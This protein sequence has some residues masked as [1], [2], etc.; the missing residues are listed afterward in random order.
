M[1]II[2][3]SASTANT[4]VG[5][6]ITYTLAVTNNETFNLFDISVSD[7]LSSSLKFVSN[8]VKINGLDSPGDS[9]LSGIFLGT[10]EPLKL[11]TV[12]F[13]AEV[14]SQPDNKEIIN[15]AIGE[16]SYIDPE[17]ALPRF[18]TAT[19][20]PFELTVNSVNLN[21]LKKSDKKVVSIGDVVT[22]TVN[23]INTGDVNLINV[24][25]IDILPPGL[26]LINGTFTINGSVLNNVNLA[27]GVIIPSI[28]VGTT[29]LIT[30]QVRVIST[31]SCDAINEARARY[32][33]V[34]ADG[35]SG[36]G[37]SKITSDSVVALRTNI[38]NFKQLSVEEYLEIPHQKPD[39]ETINNVSGKVD[40]IKCAV[41][42]TGPSVSS[43]GQK[44]TNYKLIVQ[45]ILHV[46]IEY[47]SCT[48][49]QNVHSTHFSIPFSTFIVLPVDFVPGGK[50]D[51][52]G[53]IEDVYAKEI[54]CRRLFVNTTILLTANVQSC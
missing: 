38:S 34:L 11:I 14:I 5:S 37:E 49:G 3:K 9:I 41:I 19:S 13:D 16:F 51:P 32:R 43:E 44:L 46:V 52:H 40:M 10:L 28:P 2:T 53:I 48:P 17:T 29:V 33:Y 36:I 24:Q 45:G 31:S 1:L 39:L 6:I 7:S 15:S 21:V 30:Y 42:K 27:T 22:Y 4:T 12:T 35:T 23:L 8:S 25:F 18:G 26:E 54:D 20:N 50:V 47:T